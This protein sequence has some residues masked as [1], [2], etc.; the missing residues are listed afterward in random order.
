MSMI[1]WD[2]ARDI[3]S[4]RHAMDRLFE[5]SVVRP[6]SF[7]FEMGTGNIPVDMYQTNDAVVIKA[8]L[9]GVKPEEVDISIADDAITIKAEQKEE[10]EIKEEDYVRREIRYGMV[11]RSLSLPVDVKADKAEAIFENG[12]LTVTLPKAEE[13]KPK[14]I[15]VQTKAKASEKGS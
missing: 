8:P 3:M 2:P 10:K 7:S 4:L 5:E 14:Q 1:R 13:V 12:V 11:S 15:K 6:S 9:A